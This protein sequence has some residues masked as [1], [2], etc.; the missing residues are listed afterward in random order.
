MK[1]IFWENSTLFPSA[2]ITVTNAMQVGKSKDSRTAVNLK[3]LGSFKLP[4]NHLVS[5]LKGRYGC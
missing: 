5:L 1:P 2:G 4:L 3:P